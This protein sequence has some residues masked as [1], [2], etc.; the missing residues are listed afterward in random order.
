MKNNKGFTLIELLAVI[1]IMG[2]L[3]LVG[4]PAIG[5]TIENVR[6]DSF[7]DIAAKY[8]DAV[9]NGV[10]ND[11]IKCGD[12]V[13]SATPSG[14]YYVAITED[15]SKDLM[16]KGGKSPYGGAVMTGW[17]AFEKTVD[18]TGKTTTTYSIVLVDTGK[19]GLE[20]SGK[21]EFLE[22]ELRRGNVVGSIDES[23]DRDI[24]DD[25][26]GANKCTVSYYDY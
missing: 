7:A 17:V 9:R 15:S 12:T 22:G 6:R 13:A 21:V 26:D 11:D 8:I 18:D 4:I 16:D 24:P 2:I 5:R 23:L 25:V 3:M 20:N 1:T 14:K 10:A 19:H